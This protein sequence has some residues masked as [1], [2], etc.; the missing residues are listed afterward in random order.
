MR[1]GMSPE[2]EDAQ[3][4]C[5]I[6]LLCHVLSVIMYAAWLTASQALCQGMNSDGTSEKA[7]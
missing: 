4:I 2:S 3:T 7:P 1:F 5:N 6:L